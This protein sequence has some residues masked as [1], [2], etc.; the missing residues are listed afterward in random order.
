MPP[1][2]KAMRGRGRVG[3]DAAVAHPYIAGGIVL[4]I[5]PIMVLG[6]VY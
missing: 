1:L 5:T 2:L 4:I 6:V 3:T